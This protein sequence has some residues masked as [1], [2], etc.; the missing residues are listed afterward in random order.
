MTSRLRCIT[1][2]C[3]LVKGEM[4]EI[5]AHD[6]VQGLRIE[7]KLR[8]LNLSCLQND[9]REDLIMHL[10]GCGWVIGQPPSI[11]NDLDRF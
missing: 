7:L 3:E 4:R 6:H 9:R 8:G 11:S 1:A 10:K 5:V 2:S